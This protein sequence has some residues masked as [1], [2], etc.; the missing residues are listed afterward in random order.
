M[1]EPL[2]V[3]L[4]GPY[5]QR[6]ELAKVARELRDRYGMVITSRWVWHGEET[7]EHPAEYWA[8]VDLRDLAD[9]DILLTFPSS[10]KG[11]GHHVEFGVALAS[12]HRI[13]V[14]GE[15]AGIFYHHSEVEWFPDIQS[16]Y[17][18]LADE[19]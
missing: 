5:G 15:R 7:P 17:D 11:T 14:I 4:A 10:E 13:I 2:K 9:A 18:E 3:Y 12:G 19:V 8:D 16:F 1:T 6:Q